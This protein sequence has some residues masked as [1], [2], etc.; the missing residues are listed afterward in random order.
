MLRWNPSRCSS[1]ATSFNFSI[2]PWFSMHLPWHHHQYQ[3]GDY[4][5]LIHTSWFD[6]VV[7]NHTIAQRVFVF[8]IWFPRFRVHYL[9][10][11]S[12]FPLLYL[13]FTLLCC[14]NTQM[15]TF[16]YFWK[17]NR[18]HGVW[19]VCTCLCFSQVQMQMYLFADSAS[20]FSFSKQRLAFRLL[21][22]K[23][24]AKSK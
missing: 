20:I 3:R 24:I 8:T 15:Q 23:Q 11:S 18:E 17:T 16:V 7:S 6:C 2:F 4:R 13:V 10:V 14:I 5:N 19:L 22:K 1:D 21:S 12:L 9:R